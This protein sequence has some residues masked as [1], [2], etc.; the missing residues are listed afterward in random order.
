MKKF[1]SL[2]I[3]AAIIGVFAKA[4][5]FAAQTDTFVINVTCQ[6]ETS[7]NV[8]TGTAAGERDATGFEALI[9]SV[10]LPTGWSTVLPTPLAIWNNSP[11]YA[12]SIQKY[13]LQA[14]A[15]STSL[16]P[17][18]GAG[19]WNTTTG[20]G[21]AD[22]WLLAGAFTKAAATMVTTEFTADAADLIYKT[23]PKT[24]VAAGGLHS[25]ATSGER[26]ATEA[27]HPRNTGT[28]DLFLWI[29]VGTPAASSSSGY[30][31]SFTVTV[32]AE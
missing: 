13:N 14:T 26:Y 25:P 16:L 21:L 5:I 17:A 19:S 28:A 6:R 24:W 23:A 15:G 3:V 18:D 30:N 32:G 29:G 27:A 10:N 11:A 12:A 9:S 22:T 1:L 2:V 4:D 8:T 7:V 31:P 20:S